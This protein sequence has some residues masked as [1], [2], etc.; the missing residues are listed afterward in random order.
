[1]EKGRVKFFDEKKGFGFI[2]IK[3]QKQDV[4]IGSDSF[5]GFIPK[6]GDIVKFEIKYQQEGP[7]AR[8]M[9]LIKRFSPIKKSIPIGYK[10]PKDTQDFVKKNIKNF[11][12]FNLVYQKYIR[13]NNK[14]KF[15]KPNTNNINFKYLDQYKIKFE[16]NLKQKDKN[17]EFKGFK[18]KTA[19]RL[20]IG[21]GSPSV[22]E[23][24]LKLDHIYGFPF[25]PG[26]ALKGI[27]RNYLI[28]EH[29]RN[30]NNEADEE[31][32]LKD[33]GF[34]D[35]FG[36][37]KESVYEEERQGKVFFLDSIPNEA[38]KIEKD[39]MTPHYGDY[40]KSKGEKPPADY[41]S[42]DIIDFLGVSKNIEFNF[43]LG[44]KKKDL[45]LKITKN[46]NLVDDDTPIL[47]FIKNK[48]RE[49]LEFQGV[50][51]KTAVG[52]GYFYDFNEIELKS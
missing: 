30:S 5:E 13:I 11:N 47:D 51:G 46:S 39:V 52:Y 23:T 35:I 7:H 22:I 36:C 16:S 14:N 45:K 43:Y 25:I 27:L 6:E 38:P 28:N 49:A 33:K 9:Q 40:Y 31:L 2:E 21:F 1:M 34:C 15:E 10:L 12:N 17:Y 48:L 37:P 32:A 26:S 44:I 20:L 24:S 41:Y 3:K 50:G 18:G 42:P 29:F 8:K 4:H 19:S